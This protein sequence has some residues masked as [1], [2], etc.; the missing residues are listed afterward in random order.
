MTTIPPTGGV[1]PSTTPTTPTTESYNAKT[2]TEEQRVLS[3]ELAGA[4]GGLQKM[5]AEPTPS[6]GIKIISPANPK[7]AVKLNPNPPLLAN[8]FVRGLLGLVIGA[9]LG[10]VA[11]WLLDALDKTT[12]D[13]KATRRRSS[14]CP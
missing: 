1:V 4:I 5:L 8:A 2:V 6:T 3:G 14:A 9:L 12:S 11:T 13:I 7:Q 10:V